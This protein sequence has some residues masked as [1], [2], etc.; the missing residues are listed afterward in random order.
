MSKGKIKRIFIDHWD[1]FAKL[2]KHRIRKV[3]F[4][5]VEKIINCGSIENG[6]IEYECEACGETKKVGFRCRS[7][8]CNSCGKVY[9]DDR[10]ENMASKLV[11]TKHRHIVFTIPQELRKYFQKDRKLL[12]ILPKCA[13]KVLQSWFKERN[14]KENFTPGIVAVIHTFGRDLKWNPHVHMLVT[15]GAAGEYTI[16]KKFSFIPYKM[17][18]KRWQKLLLDALEKK[19]GKRKIRRL[20]NKLYKEL[21]E[22]FYVYGKGEV[23]NEK[24]AI[25]YVGRYTG[26]PAIAESRIIDYNG[27]EVTY[28][29]ERHEDGKRVEKTVDALEFIKK[30]MIHIPEKQF[31]MIRYYGIY[32]KRAKPRKKLI[33]MVSDKV[34]E[35]KEKARKWRLRIMKSFGHDPLDCP[36]CKTKMIMKDIYYKKYGSMLERYRQ[37]ML[38][39]A[40]RAIKEVEEMYNSVKQASNGR[41]EPIFR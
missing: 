25:Q 24:S 13:S 19:V 32:A 21:E 22:G 15:E 9:V 35:Y 3:V 7:R 40:D 8:F 41:I 17:L 16:W 36:K 12:S 33:K 31:K 28:Y 5:E 2:Y 37:R 20:K 39:E 29:Y 14:K 1:E 27:E 10:A 34:K 30:I 38:A 18:R 11:N 23:K 4:K 26:R 6:Y